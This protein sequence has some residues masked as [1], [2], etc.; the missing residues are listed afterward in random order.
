MSAT[1]TLTWPK[2][3][4]APKV[5]TVAIG[6]LRSEW[7]KLLP[8]ARTNNVFV[9]WHFLATW[10]E[11][12]R[13]HREARVYVVRDDAGRV[14]GIVPLY[15]EQL[16]T[17]LGRVNVLRNIGYADVVNPDFL[18]AVVE[19]GREEEVATALEDV[20]F[21][22]PSWEFADFSELE[23]K[24]SLVRMAKIWERRG[25]VGLRIEQRS[26]CPYVRLPA[27]FE[28]YLKGR[29]P[30]FR[31]QLRRY[32][33]KIEKDLDIDWKLVGHD[34]EVAAGIEQLAR[35]HQ[36]RMEATERG[37]NFKKDDYLVFHR[38]LA[39]RMARTGQ[40]HFW[41]IFVGGAAAATHYGFLHDGVY[42]GYQMGF[43]H[44]YHKYSPG[45]YM[46]GKVMEGL[47]DAGATEMNFLRGTDGW[48]FRWTESTRR[49]VSARMLRPQ[50]RSNWARV[51]TELSGSPALVMR[52]LIGRDAF[53]EIRG[54]WKEL[55][56]KVKGQDKRGKKK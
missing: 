56:G 1:P 38:N 31:Q 19:A 48:K 54:A 55:Q 51:R 47:I 37:G 10:W 20:L 17:R 52:F 53:D 46:T 25:H 16:S 50:W 44:R 3:A 34:V 13:R 11:H 33:R 28:D 18:D 42:Y 14:I 5:E 30:H 45:H 49:T 21:E 26:I 22:D 8:V 36:E 23:P 24:G 43:T 27:T 32:R 39:E 29:N 41:L 6:S 35:L 4:A 12:F 40:L 7:S 15:V 9:S 2:R